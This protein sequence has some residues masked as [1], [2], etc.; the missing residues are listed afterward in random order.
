MLH[1]AFLH[2]PAGGQIAY[3]RQALDSLETQI[4][5]A[6]LLRAAQRLAADAFSPVLAM[7]H[8]PH[9]GFPVVSIDIHQVN[10]AH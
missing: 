5:K 3:D 9:I 7:H 8:D 4:P 6:E 2:H 1:P 10:R